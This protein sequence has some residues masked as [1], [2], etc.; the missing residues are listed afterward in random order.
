MIE[1]RKGIVN[2]EEENEWDEVRKSERETQWN[3][4]RMGRR[5]RER[6]K[7]RTKKKEKRKILWMKMK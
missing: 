5:V 4:K 3:K 7:K 6:K 2:V 1:G